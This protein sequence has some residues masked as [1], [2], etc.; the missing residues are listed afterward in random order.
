MERAERQPAQPQDDVLD[1]AIDASSFLTC[2]VAAAADL[3]CRSCFAQ[4]PV[5]RVVGSHEKKGK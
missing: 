5:T 2:V 4:H 1:F 3:P